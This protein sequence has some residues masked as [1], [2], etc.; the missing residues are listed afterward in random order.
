MKISFIILTSLKEK[1]GLALFNNG[2]K[3]RGTIP[4]VTIFHNNRVIA[5]D[6]YEIQSVKNFIG[7]LCKK[8]SSSK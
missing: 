5:D 1:I 8:E 6:N 4:H 3:Y 7:Y 2:I